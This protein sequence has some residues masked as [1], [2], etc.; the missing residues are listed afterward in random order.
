MVAGASISSV[1]GQV[2][3]NC[4][5]TSY[6]GYLS[7]KYHSGIYRL[8]VVNSV[9]RTGMTTPEFSLLVFLDRVAGSQHK[10]ILS[11]E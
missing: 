7:I 10:T 4:V 1:K 8:A 5:W 2:V 11:S 3:L 9:I 6:S